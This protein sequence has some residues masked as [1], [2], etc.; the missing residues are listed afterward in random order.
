MGGMYVPL[1]GWT[2]LRRTDNGWP[3]E[4]GRGSFVFHYITVKISTGR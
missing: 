3:P 1:E 2:P 4:A